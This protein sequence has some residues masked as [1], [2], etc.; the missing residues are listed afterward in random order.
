MPARSRARAV[1]ACGPR[2]QPGRT[3]ETRAD[4]RALSKYYGA[5]RGTLAAAY[6]LWMAILASQGAV[7][8]QSTPYAGVL[9]EHPA[10]RY[11]TAPTHDRVARLN[12]ALAAGSRSL[13]SRPDSGY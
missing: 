7:A 9:D 5:M 1:Y 10:I 2:L 12:E 6:A 4:A 3:D 8:G 13:A 11:A